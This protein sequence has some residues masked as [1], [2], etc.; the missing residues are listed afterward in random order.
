MDCKQVLFI[1]VRCL[2][3]SQFRNLLV[4]KISSMMHRIIFIIFGLLIVAQ[5][6]SAYIKR[7]APDDV[8]KFVDQSDDAEPIREKIRT[9][10]DQYKRLREMSLKKKGSKTT[11]ASTTTTEATSTVR[12]VHLIGHEEAELGDVPEAELGETPE[13]VPE[14]SEGGGGVMDLNIFD[15]PI[16]CKPG[17][18]LVGTRCRKLAK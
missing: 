5:V 3:L 16:V 2:V 11:A 12:R 7:Q 15:A 8:I 18:V 4:D 13:E 6:Q 14:E 9:E 1:P 17:F 10:M